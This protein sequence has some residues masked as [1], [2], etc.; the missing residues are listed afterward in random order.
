MLSAQL[1]N[2][3][4]KICKMKLLIHSSSFGVSTLFLLK[5]IFRLDKVRVCLTGF[6][7]IFAV[8]LV[9]KVRLSKCMDLNPKF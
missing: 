8:V 1:L 5:T 2:Q 7:A 3:I 4:N 6:G 9:F